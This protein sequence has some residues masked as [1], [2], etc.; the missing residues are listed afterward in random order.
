MTA[1]EYLLRNDSDRFANV[2]SKAHF[3][4]FPLFK[5]TFSEIEN[6]PTNGY[7]QSVVW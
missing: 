7:F 4:S 6:A 3:L 5:I 1:L 2:L